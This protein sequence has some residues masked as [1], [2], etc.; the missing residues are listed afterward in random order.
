MNQQAIR[1]FMQKLNELAH[2]LDSSRMT[3]YRRCD[4]ARDI[5]DVYSPSI[6]AGW[7][8]GRYT[9]YEASLVKQRERVK[10]LFHAEWGAD[11][12]AGRHSE[13]PDRAL[14]LVTT[15]KGTDERG[16]AYLNTGGYARL[17][18]DGDWSETYACN[19]FDWH[20]KVAG[21]TAVADGRGAMGIQGFHYAAAG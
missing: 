20:L 3:T 14:A 12:H 18:R 1:G 9:E 6:W 21:V 17:S 8:S 4:F 5:P 16:L 13:D 2:N 10:R 11:S 7:Y 15:G 19:L